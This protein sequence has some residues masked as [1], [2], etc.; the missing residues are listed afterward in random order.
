MDVFVTVAVLMG[1]AALFSFINEVTIRLEKTIALMLFALVASLLLAV[2]DAA[3]VVDFLDE[4]RQIVSRLN[5]SDTLL[6]GVLCFMLFAGSVNVKFKLLEREKWLIGS[7]AIGGTLIAWFLTG[8]LIWGVTILFGLD[9]DPIYAFLF[10][11]LIAP[12]DPIAALAILS[13]VGLPDRLE[14]IISGESLFNDGVGVVIFTMCL[15]LAISPE[16][17]GLGDAV[18]LFLREVVGGV[19]LG[20]CVAFLMRW[21][22]DRT[23]DFGSHLMITLS[24]VA[25]GYALAL[26]IEVSGPIAMVVTG[27]TIGNLRTRKERREVHEVVAGFWHGIDEV[28]NAMLFVL[29]GLSVVLV[30]PVET[31]PAAISAIVVCLIA[32]A[33]SVLVPILVVGRTPALN[34]DVWGLTG[35]LTWGGLRGGLSLAL[36]LSIPGIPEK[37]AILY[38]TFAVV[39]FSII[40]QGLSVGRLFKPERLRRLLH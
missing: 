9:I 13:K 25:L 29:I 11:A 35:L 3:G 10:G 39:A 37:G 32:R 5:L 12:T 31:F 20:L 15:A 7:L 40:V 14:A 17:P 38:M 30:A 28:L 18:V 22:L 34:A 24:L 16:P 2:L 6:N 23:R 33:A 26:G 27:L 1:L 4:Q 36:A 21:M 8:S 19:V